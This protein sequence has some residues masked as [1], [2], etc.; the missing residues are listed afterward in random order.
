MTFK[1][2]IPR[3]IVQSSE[4]ETVR[5]LQ[6]LIA[7]VQKIETNGT[8]PLDAVSPRPATAGDAV[9][10]IVIEPETVTG[11]ATFV[12]DPDVPE[13]GVASVTFYGNG[14]ATNFS[15]PVS[16]AGITNP[17]ELTVVIDGA[18]QSSSQFS[19]TGGTLT[20]TTPPP[21]AP[22]YQ[23]PNIFVKWTPDT[24]AIAQLVNVIKAVVNA[25][26][27]LLDLAI[28]V[29]NQHAEL[30]KL[31]TDTIN[32]LIDSLKQGGALK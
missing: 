9:D 3:N 18:A 4:R 12:I 24:L 31:E 14:T 8:I 32:A 23:D 5:L 16:W 22:T 11:S 2:Q 6:D 19:V 10:K 15:L 21:F 27:A 25:D 30:L 26:A 1:N 20:F 28:D 17:D 29:I 7:R 13:V